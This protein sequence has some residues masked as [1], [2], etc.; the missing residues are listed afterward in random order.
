MAKRVLRSFGRV[1]I[2]TFSELQTVCFEAAN[3]VNERPIGRNQTSPDDGTY[4]CPNELL[5][6]RATSRIPSG[7]FRETA[8]PNHRHEFVQKIIDAFWKKWIRDH[9]PSLIVQ[10]KWHTAQRDL[11]VGDVVLIQDSNQVRG[12]WKLGRVSKVKPGNDGKVRNVEV[13]YKNPKSGEPINKY[14]GQDYV[15]VER[16]VH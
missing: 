8:N 16:L 1:N 13:Q 6:G 9:F 5:L 15:T 2:L 12:N 14:G 4:L 7:P 3:L 11:M 10:Q